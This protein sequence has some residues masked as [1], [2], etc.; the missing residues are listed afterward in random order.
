MAFKFIHPSNIIVSGPTGCGK[1]W[2]VERVLREKLFDP[3]PSGGINWYY[4]EWQPAYDRM[5]AEH[6]ERIRF[7][8]GLPEQQLNDCL[9]VIDDQM[10]DACSSKTISNI[11]TKGSHHRKISVMLL[12]QN[13][14]LRAKQ[15][16]TISLNT[17]YYVIFKSPRDKSQIMCLGQQMYPNNSSFLVASFMDATSVEAHGYL[18]VD[19]RNE[20]EESL[21]V[22]T[23]VFPSDGESSIQVYLPV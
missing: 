6:G 8:Q 21:R 22:L 10:E 11:F 23:R 1:T 20:T 7:I 4:S 12:V 14:F 5:S 16:R 19:L 15:C 9:I 3:L 2:F 13:M 17:H 18:V